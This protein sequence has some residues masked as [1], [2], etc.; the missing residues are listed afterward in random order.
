MDEYKKKILCSY[1][2]H[3]QFKGLELQAPS[4]PSCRDTYLLDQKH[5]A[6]H[7][8]LT[9]THADILKCQ[10]YMYK[11]TWILLIVVVKGRS[12]KHH[13][14]RCRTISSVA[15]VPWHVCSSPCMCIVRGIFLMKSI[16][17]DTAAAAA[18]SSG[19]SQRHECIVVRSPVCKT[20]CILWWC[21][22][23]IW[24]IILV[25]SWR[26]WEQSLDLGRDSVI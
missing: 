17:V 3:S 8:Q 5:P 7:T 14:H 21:S 23:A 12:L 19:M 26:M 2:L 13:I 18:E 16:A 22:V 11:Y 24:K 6:P 1:L 15:R 20:P 25:A 9:Q 4:P 10:M